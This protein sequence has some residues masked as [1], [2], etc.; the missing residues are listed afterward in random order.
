MTTTMLELQGRVVPLQRADPDAHLIGRVRFGPEI[1]PP[2]PHPGSVG[3]VASDSG[4][5]VVEGFRARRAEPPAGVHQIDVGD[6]YIYPGLTDLHSHLG[7]A[8]L[9]MWDEPTRTKGPWLHR[10]LWPGAPSY[11]EHV[12][13]PAYA[14]MKGA[15]EALLAYAQVRALAGGTTTI[16]GWPPAKG[17][18]V[19]RFV[20]SVDDDI[21]REAIRTSVINLRPSELDDRRQHLDHDRALVYHLSEGQRDSK[22]AREFT[23][24]A[25][26]GCLRFRLI[27]IHCCAVGPA[28]FRQ[29]NLHA[30]R[31]AGE[32][33]P[34]GIV[35][36]PLSN[37]WLYGQTT[38]VVSAM[39]EGITVCLGSDWGPSGTK[40][41]LGEMKVAV[42]WIQRAGL[43]SITAFDLAKMV[44]ANPGDLLERAWGRG[45][46]RFEEGRLADAVVITRRHDDPWKNLVLA[47]ESDIELVVAN[48]RAVYGDRARMRSAGERLTTAVRFGGRSKHVPLRRPDDPGRRW[49]WTDVMEELSAVQADPVQAIENGLNAEAAHF[50]D[51]PDGPAPRLILESDMPGGPGSVAGP[52]PPGTVFQAPEIPGIVHDRAWYASLRSPRGWHDEVL[53]DIDQLFADD[54]DW[55]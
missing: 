21:D 8:T 46:G 15:P 13:W 43:D 11:R 1:D 3:G 31:V 32:Q 28:E 9:P 18:P 22:V 51:G 29:W 27:A 26:A 42:R 39:A 41:L 23:E 47:R 37:L 2:S 38:D 4:P 44:T 36:S 20:R 35:W 50:E 52:P 12:S 10:D 5:M 55:S 40:N 25:T 48:G 6:A 49:T 54:G 30:T 33:A 34:G 53:D 14:Y 7:F 19:N 17:I 24:A 16:Q 45:P